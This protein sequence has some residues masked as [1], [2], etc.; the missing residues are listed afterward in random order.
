MSNVTMSHTR[1]AGGIAA[2]PA[3][4]IALLDRVSVAVPQLLF[5]F[6]VGFVFWRSAQIKLASWDTTL[7]LF[8]EEYKVPLAAAGTRRLPGDRSG[9]DGPDLP[10]PRPCRAA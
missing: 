8:R 2:L 7:L 6:G 3:R 4:A 5:R 9:A 10:R 1:S